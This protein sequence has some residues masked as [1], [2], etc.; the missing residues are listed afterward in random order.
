MIDR[1]GKSLIK[2]MIM[3]LGVFVMFRIRLMVI[4]A[5]LFMIFSLKVGFTLSA[6][7]KAQPTGVSKLAQNL[8]QRDQF[9]NDIIN[10]F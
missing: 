10:D 6:K 9:I 8:D 5:V 1:G 7:S 2:V 3:K 4:L